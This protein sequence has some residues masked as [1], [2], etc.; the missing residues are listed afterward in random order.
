LAMRVG[1]SISK[2]DFKK[3]FAVLTFVDPGQ[4]FVNR[5]SQGV[6][7]RLRELSEKKLYPLIRFVRKKLLSRNSFY[8]ML[9]LNNNYFAIFIMKP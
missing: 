9:R 5:V 8:L 4:E 1:L 6:L 2:E 7:S 3:L